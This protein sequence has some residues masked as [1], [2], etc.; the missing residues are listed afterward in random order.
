MKAPKDSN[1]VENYVYRDAKTED[2]VMVVVVEG[3]NVTYITPDNKW[4]SCSLSQFKKGFTPG[5]VSDYDMFE[6]E[7][8]PFSEN[9]IGFININESIY[10]IKSKGNTKI[11][12]ID[13]TG[14]NFVIS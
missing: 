3:D 5:K 10:P 7:I 2:A 12:C 14:E 9:A 11:V 8:P 4:K 13:E 1:P 6:S